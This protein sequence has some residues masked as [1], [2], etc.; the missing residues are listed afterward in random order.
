[1]SVFITTNKNTR[2]NTK[3]QEISF[4]ELIGWANRLSAILINGN[5]N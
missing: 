1:M 5:K 2:M 4:Q 3:K